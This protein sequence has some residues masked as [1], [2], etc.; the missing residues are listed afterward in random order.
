MGSITAYGG[1]FASAFLAATLLPGSSEALL[2]H[3]LVTGDHLPWAL[4]AVATVGNVLGSVVNW[5]CGRF[6]AAFQA[7][8]WFPVSPKRYAQAVG[9]FERFGLW[10]L[11]FAWAPIVGDPL[12]VIAGTLQVRLLPFLVLVTIGKFARYMVVFSVA[13]AWTG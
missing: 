4:V 1:L 8:W 12:T 6:L 9:W 7:R 5:V 10:S 2:T 13:L 3:L 11:L